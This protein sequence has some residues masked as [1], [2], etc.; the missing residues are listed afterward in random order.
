[1][2]ESG[3]N[4][5]IHTVSGAESSES[6]HESWR[7]KLVKRVHLDSKPQ[8]AGI[9]GSQSGRIPHPQPTAVHNV[10]AVLW[11]LWDESS[12]KMNMSQLVTLSAE[13]EYRLFE[14]Q[15]VPTSFEPL[16][17]VMDLHSF[18]KHRETNG[19]RTIPKF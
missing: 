9:M 5:R 13:K 10:I 4:V 16:N 8:G 1:M 15:F 14:K 3:S 12:I 2:G 7:S 18:R 6:G 17:I 11:I 19:N